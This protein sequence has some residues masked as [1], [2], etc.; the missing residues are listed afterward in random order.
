MSVAWLSLVDRWRMDWLFCSVSNL[1]FFLFILVHSFFVRI[2]AP[3]ARPQHFRLARYFLKELRILSGKDERSL[4]PKGKD[5]ASIKEVWSRW[6]GVTRCIT[7][8]LKDDANGDKWSQRRRC[9]QRWV[10][11]MLTADSERMMKGNEGGGRDDNWRLPLRCNLILFCSFLSCSFLSSQAP[12]VFPLP[13]LPPPQLP[14]SPRCQQRRLFPF[15]KNSALKEEW[16]P[17]MTLSPMK[18]K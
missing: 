6:L 18:V 4:T 9:A 5:Q 7:S 8:V 2:S 3:L 1:N 11:L 10:R 17:R 16:R 15:Y 13:P 12:R 14:S